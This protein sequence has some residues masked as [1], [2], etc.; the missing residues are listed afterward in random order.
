MPTLAEQRKSE[1][2]AQ[3]RQV[4]MAAIAYVIEN[5]PEVAANSLGRGL[6]QAIHDFDAAWAALQQIRDFNPPQ[7]G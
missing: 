1:L 4:A 3:A 2:D 6:I 7:E 5:Y